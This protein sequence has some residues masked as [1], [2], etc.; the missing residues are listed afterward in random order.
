MHRRARFHLIAVAAALT[1]S[2]APMFV[3]NGTPV[4]ASQPPAGSFMDY[5]DDA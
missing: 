5:T 3:P 4:R 2:A 1:L